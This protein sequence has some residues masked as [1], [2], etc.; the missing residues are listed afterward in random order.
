MVQLGV[1]MLLEMT[2]KH[3]QLSLDIGQGFL[4][5]V[6]D[7][8]LHSCVPPIG[9]TIAKFLNLY[10]YIFRLK[11]FEFAAVVITVLLYLLFG[12]DW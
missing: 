6:G 3:C 10:M 2:G 8:V 12:L 7:W 1:G 5:W 11:H 9:S 4:E